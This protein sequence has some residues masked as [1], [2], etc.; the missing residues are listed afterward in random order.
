MNTIELSQDLI[1]IPSISGNFT[2]TRHCIDYCKNYFKNFNNVKIKEIEIN[3]TPS[4]LLSNYDGLDFDIIS[5]GHIDVVPVEDDKMFVPEIKDG[6]LY[7]RGSYDMKSL[8]AV[9]MKMLEYVLKITLNTNLV[10]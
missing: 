7:G 6:K 3:N 4:V 5:I 8:V 10:F 2:E 9:S 1:K